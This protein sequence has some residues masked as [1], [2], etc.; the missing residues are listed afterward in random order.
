MEGILFK[1]SD[2]LQSW[3]RRA[4][5]LTASSSPTLQYYRNA[6]EEYPANS[7][8]LKGGRCKAAGTAKSGTL[9]RVAAAAAQ[10]QAH[11]AQP[12]GTNGFHGDALRQRLKS[13][14]VQP[15][16][17][18]PATSAG[19]QQRRISRLG[20]ASQSGEVSTPQLSPAPS[21]RS[22]LSPAASLM[23][24]QPRSPAL[25]KRNSFNGP[26]SASAR[27]SEAALRAICSFPGSAASGRQGVSGDGS[28][29]KATPAASP[30]TPISA[31]QRTW[32]GH[33]RSSFLNAPSVISDT[34]YM[35]EFVQ[36]GAG[37]AFSEYNAGLQE[38]NVPAPRARMIKAAESGL[39]ADAL[40]EQFQRAEGYAV[41][42]AQE[43]SSDAKHQLEGWA[44]AVT[45]Q[46]K[47][48][49]RVAA[50]AMYILEVTKVNA[51][52]AAWSD[53]DTAFVSPDNMME[54]VRRWPS[55]KT[56]EDLKD[57]LDFCSTQWTSLFCRLGG[58]P[59]LLQA[60]HLHL[61]AVEEGAGLGEAQDAV[62]AALSAMH[63][64]LSGNQGINPRPEYCSALV[65]MLQADEPEIWD[66]E[67]SNHVLS[68]IL[69]VLSSPEGPSNAALRRRFAARMLECGLR[70]AASRLHVLADP[71]ISSAA[72][73]VT[74]HIDKIVQL[75]KPAQKAVKLAVKPMHVA[76]PAPPPPPPLPVPKAPGA[77]APPPLPPGMM[78]RGRGRGAPPPPPMGI[79]PSG[80]RTPAGPQP[81]RK[82]KSFFWD[83]LPDS[84]V[85]ATFWEHHHPDYRA[86]NT[87]EVEDLFQANQARGVAQKAKGSTAKQLAVLELKRA[88]TIGIRM[89]RLRV[90][91]EAVSIAIETLDPAVF[92]SAED[93]HTVLACL[94]TEEERALLDSFVRLGGQTSSLTPAELF[95]LDLMKVP[96]VEARLVTFLARFEA[97]ALLGEA[98]DIALV[99]LQAQAQLRTS[100]TLAA[101]LEVVLALGNFLN[102]GTRLG[103]ASGFRLKN[104]FKL[105]DTRSLDGHISMQK[106]MAQQLCNR[107]PPCPVLSEELSAVVSPLLTTSLQGISE[108]VERVAAALSGVR[109]ELNRITRM[110]SL[111]LEVR[112]DHIGLE[113]VPDNYYHVMSATLQAAQED[114]A[115]VRVLQAQARDGLASLLAFYGENVAAYASDSEFWSGLAAFVTAFGGVQ[116]D[117][118][119]GMKEAEEVQRRREQRDGRSS[120]RGTPSKVQSTTAEGKHGATS[121]HSPI[122]NPSPA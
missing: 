68:F 29:P 13:S 72:K 81:Q 14:G 100:A 49:A 102:W 25:L 88:T 52:W 97:A 85:P 1:R 40:L 50:A 53:S 20:S 84:R 3:N 73:N 48:E 8:D 41:R 86:V 22:S 99:H 95:C 118:F 62:A 115:G 70:R 28:T 10:A 83:K 33:L 79:R 37:P 61:T 26:G 93:V 98:R 121:D 19:L 104:L 45:G 113:L 42:H 64:L 63:A 34:S 92:C 47:S 107:Q 55:S 80:P 38:L 59:L 120:Q 36:D 35:S 114:M 54:E 78:G 30:I 51:N 109:V 94:P 112:Q 57:C 16:T 60:L 24:P 71:Y 4:F 66:A 69:V 103:A 46:G 101:L 9:F 119:K 105:Q 106:Y 111:R 77:P 18:A 91:W 110:V 15:D 67:L 7:L 31:K 44:K 43:F 5:Q 116:A 96:R 122:P 23:G 21:L 89:A 2:V 11:A 87:R 32:M 56:L 90:P 65:I 75:P 27:N 6:E 58:A 74:D 76:L 39:L 82:L 17:L 108:L 12:G 117:I